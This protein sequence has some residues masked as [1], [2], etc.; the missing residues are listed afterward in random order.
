MAQSAA[1]A[2]RRYLES[3]GVPV[4][5]GRRP[6]AS[7]ELEA[8]L[9]TVQAKIDATDNVV[10]RLHLHQKALELEALLQGQNSGA[11]AA[12]Q[13]EADF[14]EHVKTWAAKNQVSYGALRKAGVPARVLK[15][16]GMLP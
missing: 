1:K 10:A 12:A 7:A 6:R 14:V 2:V 13:I 15:Q 4:R 8:D 5:R 16:A 9:A 3:L 11:D